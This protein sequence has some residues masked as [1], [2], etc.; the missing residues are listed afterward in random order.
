MRK[1]AC[2]ES[3]E[4]SILGTGGSRFLSKQSLFLGEEQPFLW[5]HWFDV[6]FE[7]MMVAKA[8]TELA[9]Q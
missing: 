2:S 6:T 3:F 5:K 9:Y 4:I 1:K 8:V 7:N